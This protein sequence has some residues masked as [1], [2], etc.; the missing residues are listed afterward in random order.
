[1]SKLSNTKMMVVIRTR[2]IG[3]FRFEDI[4][5]NWEIETSELEL[6]QR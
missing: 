3:N 6:E 4:L 5:P 2:H 1:M